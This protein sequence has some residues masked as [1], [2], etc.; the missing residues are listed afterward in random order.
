[1]WF[2]H[3]WKEGET[4]KDEDG[5]DGRQIR[6]VRRVLN[7]KVVQWLYCQSQLQSKDSNQE[8]KK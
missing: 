2:F 5:M 4:Y 1:V 7:H 8:Q 3:R 6:R